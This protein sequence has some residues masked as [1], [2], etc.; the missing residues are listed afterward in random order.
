MVQHHVN[1]CTSLTNGLS[2]PAVNL[3]K[4]QICCSY[5]NSFEFDELFKRLLTNRL[6]RCDADGAHV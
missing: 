4:T 2:V 5:F 6:C 1:K 3:S